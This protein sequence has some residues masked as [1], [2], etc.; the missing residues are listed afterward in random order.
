MLGLPDE[1][2]L[3]FLS[4]TAVDQPQAAVVGIKEFFEGIFFGIAVV[5]HTPDPGIIIFIGPV[6]PGGKN[7]RWNLRSLRYRNKGL[8]D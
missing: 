1:C 4:I 5:V 8:S 2:F 6:D 3:V 7:H